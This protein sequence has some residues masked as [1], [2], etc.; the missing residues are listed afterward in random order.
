[1]PMDRLKALWFA[2]LRW[3]L[4]ELKACIPPQLQRRLFRERSRLLFIAGDETL[5]IRHASNGSSH[6]LGR[7]S[8][9]GVPDDVVATEIRQILAGLDASRRDVL[10]CLPAGSAL[11]R[12]I[13]LPA[14]TEENLR[15]VIS[16]DMERQ[17]P[18]TDQQVYFDARVARRMPDRQRIAVALTV[19]PCSQVDATVRALQSWGVAINGIEVADPAGPPRVIPLAAQTVAVRASRSQRIAAAAMAAMAV[20]LGIGLITVPLYRQAQLSEALESEVAK[21]R[22]AADAARKTQE[23]IDHLTALDRFLIE[24]KMARPTRLATLDE[25]TRIMPDDSWLYRVRFSGDEVQTFG[26]SAAASN[27]IGPFD[28][29]P[30]FKEPQFMAPLMRDPR[31]DAERFTISLQLEKAAS[32]PQP[33]KAA[34]Q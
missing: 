27:L 13:E 33:E 19:V 28:N 3:W 30:L 16:F 31:V 34:Q 25:L 12:T 1:M 4:G 26:Y 7:L 24:R 8:V 32:S 11:R 5:T 29:S 9:T 14:A 10:L 6:E 17:T 23:E 2:F 22:K 21:T 18:F 15:E 20:L